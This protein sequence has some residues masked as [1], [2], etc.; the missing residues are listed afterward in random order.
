MFLPVQIGFTTPEQFEQDKVQDGSILKWPEVPKKVICHIETVEQI[1]T[2]SGRMTMVIS[3]VDND[4]MNL[5]PIWTGGEGGGQNGPL[6]VF[7]KY[8][9][10]GLTNPHETL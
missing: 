5:N 8:V 6:R 2:K 7:A 3:L 4:G 1:T 9:K 10:N